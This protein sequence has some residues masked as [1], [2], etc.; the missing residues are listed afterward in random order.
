MNKISTT[1]LPQTEENKK[2][3]WQRFGVK[4]EYSQNVQLT[5]QNLKDLNN[6]K[7]IKVDIVFP[8][9]NPISGLIS[10]SKITLN[11]TACQ[12]FNSLIVTDD[13][14]EPL[15][16]PETHFDTAK[17]LFFQ[18]KKCHMEILL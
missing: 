14:G 2:L 12:H 11:I 18:C 16:D 1:K 10:R 15:T 7:M 5:T 3:M 6:S 8:F 17:E 9:F 4:K 13:M